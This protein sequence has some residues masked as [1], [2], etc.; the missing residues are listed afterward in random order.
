MM[1][2]PELY[3]HCLPRCCD[4]SNTITRI[5]SIPWD[6]LEVRCDKCRRSAEGDLMLPKT[7][8]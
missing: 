1:D 6:G 5:G 8:I 3:L 4:D 7:V 2:T